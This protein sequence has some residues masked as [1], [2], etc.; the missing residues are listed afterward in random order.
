MRDNINI[1]KRNNHRRA[2]KLV[3]RRALILC[4]VITFFVCFASINV[5]AK[6]THNTVK[7]K[8]KVFVSYEVKSGDNLWTIAKEC[9]DTDYYNSY[10]KYIDEVVTI[11][12]IQGEKITAGCSITLP[13][14]Q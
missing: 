1:L 5:S 7:N 3:R 8:E 10:E 4:L 2:R 9:C 14:Y 13:V 11:N 12:K 6:S